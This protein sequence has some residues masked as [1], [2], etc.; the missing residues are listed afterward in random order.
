METAPLGGEFGIVMWLQDETGGFEAIFVL[1]MLTLSPCLCD[2]PSSFLDQMHKVQNCCWIWPCIQIS[3]W[4]KVC[5][6]KDILHLL[7]KPESK[8]SGQT[9]RNCCLLWVRL[10]SH[11]KRRTSASSLEMKREMST[12]CDAT[13]EMSRKTFESMTLLTGC[14]VMVKCW[15]M[16]KK[17]RPC[18]N[19]GWQMI[20][21][22]SSTFTIWKR[23]WAVTSSETLSFST[24][25]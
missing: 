1:I 9:R 7:E 20:K 5:L 17:A 10:H 6:Q 12:E 21:V 13:K 25:R 15:E 16:K 8:I 2:S 19:L 4:F 3:K 23:L 22:S 14:K 18:Q 11:A 24:W